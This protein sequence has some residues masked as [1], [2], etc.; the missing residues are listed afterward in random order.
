MRIE[1]R[2]NTSLRLLFFAGALLFASTVGQEAAL[3][4]SADQPLFLRCTGQQREV[5]YGVNYQVKADKS[6]PFTVTYRIAG[7]EIWDMGPT[8]PAW[9]DP[10]CATK[11]YDCEMTDARIGMNAV[12][13]WDDTTPAVTFHRRLNDLITI[14]RY[15]GAYE[16][17]QQQR[18]LRSTLP[19]GD[20]QTRD[21]V[22]FELTRSGSCARIDDPLKSIARKF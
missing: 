15:S 2:A 1:S 22:E 6:E 18:L 4:Q 8:D 13:E 14:N 21:L 11:N 20:V 9:G 19:N 16:R 10:R 7:N 17:K 12:N 3:A 5:T